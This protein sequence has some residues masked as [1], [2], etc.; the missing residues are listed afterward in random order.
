MMR[1]KGFAGK[2]AVGLLTVLMV[3]TLLPVMVP[4]SRAVYAAQSY[5]GDKKAKEIALKDAGAKEKDVSDLACKLDKED[6]EYEVSF[7]KSGYDYEYTIRARSGKIEEKEYERLGAVERNVIYKNSTALPIGLAVDGRVIA[8]KRAGLKNAKKAKIK[9]QSWRGT[10]VWKVSFK[11]GK[12]EYEYKINIY[13]GKILKME[14]E[15]DD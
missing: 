5:I 13:S 3:L 14:K 10:K 15:I 11:K 4:Q 8:C 1:K 12:Y 6:H 2:I 9:K 7:R